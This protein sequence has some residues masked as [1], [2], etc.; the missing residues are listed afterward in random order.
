MTPSSSDLSRSMSLSS[1]A[2]A[3]P[4]WSSSPS[5]PLRASA[6][7]R[8]ALLLFTQGG[9]SREPIGR[10]IYPLFLACRVENRERAR[11][12]RLGQTQRGRGGALGWFLSEPRSK[13]DF[14][15]KLIV[16][17]A[18]VVALVLPTAASAAPPNGG[19]Y[20]GA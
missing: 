11:R 17:A 13:E 7:G 19:G 8:G 15:K 14:M 6:P 2:A 10:L 20:C 16:C 12:V 9:L 5:R 1:K 3:R 18:F 4:R